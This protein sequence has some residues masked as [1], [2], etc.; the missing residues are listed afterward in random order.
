MTTMASQITSLTVV[1]ST[2]YSDA[3]QRK[4]QSSASLAFVWGIHRDRWIPL[5]KG[6]LRGKCFHMMRSSWLLH[7]WNSDEIL[8]ENTHKIKHVDFV[9]IHIVNIC[10]YMFANMFVSIYRFRTVNNGEHSR[11]ND[12]RCNTAIE[13]CGIR[14]RESPYFM[15]STEQSGYCCS[16]PRP[17]RAP[18]DIPTPFT[19]IPSPTTHRLSDFPHPNGSWCDN[20]CYFAAVFLWYE[21]PGVP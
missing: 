21:R 2:V 12:W 18:G 11:D 1:Y 19:P 9:N 15:Q 8:T 20:N 17:R 6:Q 4:H 13:I 16:F 5:T 7:R 14:R 3:D 10:K